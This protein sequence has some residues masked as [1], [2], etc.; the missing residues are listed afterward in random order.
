M[1]NG[2]YTE[3]CAQARRDLEE[4]ASIYREL[5][6]AQWVA[7]TTVLLGRV[8]ALEG[9]LDEA[10]RL[11]REALARQRELGTAGQSAWAGLCLGEALGWAGRYADSLSHLDDSMALWPDL[12]QDDDAYCSPALGST[13]LHLGQYGEADT[14]LRAALRAV[15]TVIQAQV[16]IDLGRLAIRDGKP[17][18]ARRLFLESLE[19]QEPLGVRTIAAQARCALVYAAQ[20]PD[21]LEEARHNLV[22]ALRWAAQSGAF[23]AIV[24]GLPASALMLVNQGKVEQAV[25]VYALACTFGRVANSQWYEDVVGRPI[26]AAAAALPPDVVAAAQERGRARDVQATLEELIAEWEN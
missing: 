7:E 1:L 23:R 20:A 2:F 5:G 4:S 16:L 22:Q 3:D 6:D 25:E 26:A 9:R 13:K 18:E 19:E 15:P 14:H 17:S 11:L 12:E 24:D 8:C 21:G 10:E